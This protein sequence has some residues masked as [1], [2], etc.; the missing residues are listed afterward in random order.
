LNKHDAALYYFKKSVEVRPEDPYPHYQLGRCYVNLGDM[1]NAN[2]QQ[3]ILRDLKSRLAKS[4]LRT[5]QKTEEK[6]GEVKAIND[7]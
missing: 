3:E 5:I 2:A 4:L 7:R 6:A 1:A